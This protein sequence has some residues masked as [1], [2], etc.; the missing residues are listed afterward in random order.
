MKKS[1]FIINFIDLVKIY[2]FLFFLN[3]KSLIK[4]LYSKVLE[5]SSDVFKHLDISKVSKQKKND[6]Y[7]KKNKN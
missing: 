6:N 7:N 1:H 3:V 2:F 5:L 4:I